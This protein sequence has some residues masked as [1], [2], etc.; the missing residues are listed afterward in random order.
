MYNFQIYSLLY[1]DF[2]ILYTTNEGDI[3][4]LFC[5]TKVSFIFF[6]KVSLFFFREKVSLLCSLFFNIHKLLSNYFIF[7]FINYD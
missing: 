2:Y 5:F 4:L 3:V 6:T 7:K 1:N